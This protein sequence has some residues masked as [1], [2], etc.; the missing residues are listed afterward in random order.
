MDK[1]SGA[2][3]DVPNDDAQASGRPTG[4]DPETDGGDSEATTGSGESGV[5]V[6]RTAG[7]DEGYA[8]QTGAEARGADESRDPDGT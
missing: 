3:S 1:Q 8:G 4:G 6:G 5:F 7:Q 2:E